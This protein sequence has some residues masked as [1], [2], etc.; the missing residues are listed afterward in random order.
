M[1]KKQIIKEIGKLQV[2]VLRNDTNKFDYYDEFQKLID[3]LELGVK[4][5][6][7]VKK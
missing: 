1:N 4:H 7:G 5:S 3:K 6:K 2:F